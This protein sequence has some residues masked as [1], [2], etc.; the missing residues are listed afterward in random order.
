MNSRMY[1]ITLLLNIGQ[2]ISTLVENNAYERSLLSAI[3]T[4]EGKNKIFF[5]PTYS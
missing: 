3:L 4:I 2:Q 5:L 1:L